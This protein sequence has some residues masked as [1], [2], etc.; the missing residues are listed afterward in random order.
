MGDDRP[1]EVVFQERRIDLERTFV[2]CGSRLP[3]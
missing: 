2:R 1:L 3:S